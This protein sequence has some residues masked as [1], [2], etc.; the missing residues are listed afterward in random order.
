MAHATMPSDE[1]IISKPRGTGVPPHIEKTEKAARA[2]P[3][4]RRAISGIPSIDETGG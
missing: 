3:K 2:I 4:S 1:P